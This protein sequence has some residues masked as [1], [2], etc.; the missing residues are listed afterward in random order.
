MQITCHVFYIR[1][2]NTCVLITSQLWSYS[3]KDKL[4]IGLEMYTSTLFLPITA[5]VE[6]LVLLITT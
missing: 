6:P 1:I 3:A 2:S 5:Y 4:V